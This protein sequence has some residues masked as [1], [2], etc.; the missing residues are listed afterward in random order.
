MQNILSWS[1]QTKNIEKEIKRQNK[2]KASQRS[3][4]TIRILSDTADIFA[5]FLRETVNSAIKTSKF[6]NRLKLGDITSLH[7]KD[8]KDNK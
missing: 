7:K 6:P 1:K 5:E 8:R 2:N 3:G 4:I